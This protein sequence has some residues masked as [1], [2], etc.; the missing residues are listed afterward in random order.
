MAF[1]LLKPNANFFKLK[2]LSEDNFIGCTG[3]KLTYRPLSQ[4][5]DQVWS[6]QYLSDNKYR[7]MHTKTQK[8]LSFD[9]NLKL[10]EPDGS[11][12][13]L[14][15]ALETVKKDQTFITTIT[16]CH[17]GYFVQSID[18]TLDCAEI[19][20]KSMTKWVIIQ[21]F[22]ENACVNWPLSMY[23][24]ILIGIDGVR[25]SGKT[26]VAGF[27]KN[28]L[29]YPVLSILSLD[30]FENKSSNPRIAK[31]I[32][33]DFTSEVM[34]LRATKT[35]FP[36]IILVEGNEILT[37]KT[38]IEILDFSIFLGISKEKCKE[39]KLGDSTNDFEAQWKR[40]IQY[41][42]NSPQNVIHIN[43]EAFKVGVVEYIALQI[44]SD[45]IDINSFELLLNDELPVVQNPAVTH[46]LTEGFLLGAGVGNALGMP[47]D[48]IFEKSRNYLQIYDYRIR[49]EKNVY[50]VYSYKSV[51][52]KSNQIPVG[53]YGNDT[54]IL[55]AV[56][57]SLAGKTKFSMDDCV[58]SIKELLKNNN[59]TF[60][61]R[62]GEALIKLKSGTH[63]SKC[64]IDTAGNGALIRM[65]PL[66]YHYSLQPSV[67]WKEKV[68]DV[69]NLTTLTHNHKLAIVCSLVLV[70]VL[71][72][73]FRDR[74]ALSSPESRQ[75]AFSELILLR[76]PVIM[77][78]CGLPKNE[79]GQFKRLY[80][81]I[82]LG[83]GGKND[84][85]LLSVVTNPVF[86]VD[87][88]CLILSIL[89]GM[90]PNIQSVFRAAYIGGDSDT[91]ATII[92]AVLGGIFGTSL[93][94]GYGEYLE[95]LFNGS[96]LTSAAM[97]Y[98]EK[99]IPEFQRK[100]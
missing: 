31:F 19:G 100:K 11:D 46:D 7:I 85:S 67:D 53:S 8:F 30:H 56:F 58:K 69:T 43:T 60:V 14:E 47:Y 70:E 90:E 28:I 63:W 16:S 73:L 97:L 6:F 55:L 72:G 84:A 27:L 24:P 71:E 26:S 78:A 29:L 13:K 50:E 37:S 86:S 98:M 18:S 42:L 1:C 9:G 41:S 49:N 35:A 45:L 5:K 77:E 82:E 22:N 65:V 89:F 38:L 74:Q 54:M 59:I 34:K 76:L 88:L 81:L 96:A 36:S 4:Y 25:R 32:L 94:M 68:Q 15:W 21:M 80:D 87:T 57:N 17:N 3:L 91:F 12:P 66:A 40:T 83:F 99:R 95:K 75:N 10:K 39:R 51:D 93:F 33:E 61:G 92:G 48:P 52:G 20:E 64:G 79:E 23:T 2:N 44:N 62:T